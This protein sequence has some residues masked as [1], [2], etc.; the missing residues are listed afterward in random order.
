[1]INELTE[2][3]SKAADIAA[4]V[5][6]FAEINGKT[7]RGQTDVIPQEFITNFNNDGG[8]EMVEALYDGFSVGDIIS[9]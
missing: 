7:Y 4:I 6:Y 3:L 9:W 1:M 5:L 8:T 2:A